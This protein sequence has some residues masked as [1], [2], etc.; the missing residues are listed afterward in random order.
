MTPHTAVK[1]F[2]S[3]PAIWACASFAPVRRA[4]SSRAALGRTAQTASGY[5]IASLRRANRHPPLGEFA[6]PAQ[7]RRKARPRAISAERNSDERRF[8]WTGGHPRGGQFEG[9]FIVRRLPEEQCGIGHESR[10]GGVEDRLRRVQPGVKNQNLAAVRHAV[11]CASR[12]RSRRSRLRH[13]RR[14]AR[15]PGRSFRS[16]QGARF[17]PD[18]VRGRARG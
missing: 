10:K 12:C 9:G 5:G 14:N 3:E 17:L 7:E 18:A 2:S 6:L 15:T 4:N 11:R 8:L 16:R 13:P 1:D